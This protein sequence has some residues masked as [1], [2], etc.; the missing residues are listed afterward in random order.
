MKAE[1]TSTV[2]RYALDDRA[3][4]PF[5]LLSEHTK[6][7]LLGGLDEGPENIFP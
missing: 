4:L 1:F 3:G 6:E 2:Y 7:W 5:Y